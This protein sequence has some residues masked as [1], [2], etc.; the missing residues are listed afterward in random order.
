MPKTSSK[1]AAA[2]R[3][4]RVQQAHATE[5][6]VRTTPTVRKQAQRRQQRQGLAAFVR[7]FPYAS[8][9]LIIAILASLVAIM[10]SNH[11]AFFA[12]PPNPCQ[13][14]LQSSSPAPAGATIVRSYKLPPKSCITATSPGQYQA[15]IHTARGDIVVVLDQ[16]QAPITVNNFVFLAS[17]HY[18]DGLAFSGVTQ[19]AIIGGDPRSLKQPTGLKTVTDGSDMPGY[20]I[21]PELPISQ[22]AYQ[23]QSIVMDNRPTDDVAGSRF[24]ITTQNDAA[25][26]LQYSYFGRL[27][28][29][30]LPIARKI[31]AGDKILWITI[32]YSASGIPGIALPTP[33]PTTPTP[34]PTANP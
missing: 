8:G 27:L 10:Y 28:D 30:S 23:A 26:P 22:N 25:L 1:K 19:F 21:V 7:Q 32:Q 12:L 13:W 33:A 24:F 4:A 18:Y 17:H 11:L 6:V 9:V 5:P 3:V 20:H 34:A 29:P 15:T 16:T 2:R 31:Q 14:A